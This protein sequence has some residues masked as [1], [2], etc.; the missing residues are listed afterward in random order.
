MCGP[1]N[2]VGS[3]VFFSRCKVNGK[4]PIE[5]IVDRNCESKL[6]G[7]AFAIAKGL[8]YDGFHVR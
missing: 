6:A 3:T 1:K 7:C 4:E 5:Q 2:Q 8:R